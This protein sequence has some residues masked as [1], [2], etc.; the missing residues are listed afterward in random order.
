M[1]TVSENGV[2]VY[3]FNADA[4]GGEYVYNCNK[5]MFDTIVES[6]FVW[7]RIYSG[8]VL[9][10]ELCQQ[11]SEIKRKENVTSITKNIDQELYITLVT[12]L[13]NSIKDRY[14]TF[15]EKDLYKCFTK[16][17]IFGIT[18]T[19]YKRDICRKL[20]R[21]FK[22][23]RG[24]IGAFELDMGN[25]LH[26][27]LFLKL[28]N[29]D[30][31]L[32]QNE[33]YIEKRYDQE[34]IMIPEWVRD[35]SKINIKVV[36]RKNF[37][38]YEPKLNFPVENSSA[39]ENFCN[40]M[41]LKYKE[42]HYQKICSEL[43]RN[44]KK[45]YLYTVNGKLSYDKIV[46]PKEKLVKYALDFEHQKGGKEKAE[47]FEKLLGITKDNWRYLAAQIEND[48]E[49][50]KLC[51]VRKTNYGIQYYID[52]PVKGLNGVSK[53]VRTAW[54]TKDEG[55]IAL[56][57]LYIAP[58]NE[59]QNIQGE[60]PCIVGE[61]EINDFFEILYNL[62]HTEALKAVKRVIPTP[63][64]LKDYVEPVMDGYC[65]YAYIHFKDA[66]N[67]FVKWLKKKNIGHKAYN[68][69]GWDIWAETNSQSYDKAKKYAD[70]FAKILRQNGVECTVFADYN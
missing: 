61:N 37:K 58:E 60:T 24:Y 64:F 43:L 47:L 55:K 51:N 46:I 11:I 28:M 69:A 48:I 65:G 22:E 56:V 15:G 57:T 38:I 27:I 7:S 42:D 3:L 68:N 30:G 13:V 19:N 33:L 26:I 53:D 70:T 50:G 41:N 21:L 32:K 62:A 5:M 18:I 45:D 17:N 23:F 36:N 66:R 6:D 25:P 54:I 8:D 52:I 1:S 14:N 49:D 4:I 20:D 2:Y 10:L 67:K 59:Q 35:N 16:E 12:E 63:M 31:F 39:G 9:L 29:Y 44:E 34:E 40:I